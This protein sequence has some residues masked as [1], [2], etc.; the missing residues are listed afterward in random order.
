MPLTVIIDTREQQPYSFS[1]EIKTIT[2]T[3][4]S[5]DYS[6]LGFENK[7]SIER[8]SLEDYIKSITSDRDRFFK[9]LNRLRE[10]DYAC[11]VVEGSLS[12]ILDEKYTRNILPA[13]LFGTTVSIC[14]DKKI[15][16]FFCE[17]RQHSIFFTEKMLRMYYDHYCLNKFSEDLSNGDRIPEEQSEVAIIRQGTTEEG[18]KSGTARIKHSTKSGRCEETENSSGI[19]ANKRKSRSNRKGDK[20]L[21]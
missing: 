18:I 14:I 11:I 10:F 16:V 17:D 4:K 13:G 20:N 5:G 8:K 3:L 6:I 19:K 7:F 9:E 2:Q 21:L 12:N 15:P 1:S